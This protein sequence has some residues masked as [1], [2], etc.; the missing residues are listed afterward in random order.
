MGFKFQTKNSGT[1]TGSGGVAGVTSINGKT[2]RVIL[3]SIDL[4]Y[5]NTSTGL[6]STNI[7][8]AITEL[9]TISDNSKIDI[10]NID[11][12][13]QGII[14]GSIDINSKNDCKGKVKVNALDTL[15]Y[16]DAKVDNKTIQIAN[17]KLVVKT[18]DGMNSSITEINTLVG[19]KSNI[20]AQINALSQ[21]GSFIGATDTKAELNKIASANVND[22]VIVVTDETR[23][24]GSTIYMYDGQS[25]IYVGEFKIQVRDFSTNPLDLSTET[26]GILPSNKLSNDVVLDTEIDVPFLNKITDVGGE[27]YYDGKKI[28]K[29]NEV[30]SVNG[31]KGTV[32]LDHNDVGAVAN[33]LGTCSGV[34]IGTLS[35]RP[36]TTTDNL[37]YV[38]IDKTPNEFYRYDNVKK[39]WEIIGSNFSGGSSG[40]GTVATTAIDVYF[41]NANSG[42]ASINV[43]ELGIELYNMIV[44]NKSLIDVLDADLLALKQ[45]V[46]NINTNNTSVI[47]DINDLKSNQGK[48]KS[49][50]TDILGYLDTKVDNTTIG[51]KNNKLYAISLDGL[52]SSINE[53]NFSMGLKDNIQKQLDKV[54]GMGSFKASVP[55]KADLVNIPNPVNGDI[56]IVNKDETKGGI[57]TS[58]IY[59]GT[60]W[61][62]V[63]DF[64]A[65]PRDF[66]TDP[67]DLATEV[68][69]KLPTTSIPSN[70]VTDTDIDKTVIGKIT[71]DIDGNLE[72]DNKPIK[73]GKVEITDLS[74]DLQNKI[75]SSTPSGGGGLWY[76]ED[77][78]DF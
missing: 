48:V 11:S 30:L 16:L 15:D 35:N 60:D 28:C 17:D 24:S 8:N 57:A 65:K 12:T 66:T 42:I 6:T 45:T 72:Y 37:L 75:N 64:T 9:K 34:Q 10:N 76:D 44:N 74:P 5:N 31:K 69:G 3:S 14:S 29:G 21:I 33:I 47:N 19:A 20:Q 68:I 7:Q 62:Y 63:G 73:T 70:V 23:G 18:L 32:V 67:I 53:L 71:Q 39:Q 1:S 41:N 58:H 40:V 46:A 59:D 56:A 77:N 36:L 52:T 51:V 25:W 22:T 50:S 54:V 27:I 55:T 2:G 38:V 26:T 13:I 4:R 61:V 78:A 43:Q 49:N